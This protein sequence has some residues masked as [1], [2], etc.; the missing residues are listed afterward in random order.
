MRTTLN[1]DEDVLD[2][3]KTYAR[4][5]EISLGEAANALIK[6]GL[7]A[8][9]PTRWENGFLVFDLGPEGAVTAEHVRRVWEQILEEEDKKYAGGAP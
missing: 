8:R 2:A 1:L 5:R 6:R 3:M 4:D 7:S 9:C